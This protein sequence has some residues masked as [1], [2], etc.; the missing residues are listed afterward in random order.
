MTSP[1]R[2]LSHRRQNL[3][4]NT[5][6]RKSSGRV[7]RQRSMNHVGESF[8]DV[9][10]PTGDAVFTAGTILM[11][12]GS[13]GSGGLVRLEDGRLDVAAALDPRAGPSP[14][15]S[16]RRGPLAPARNQRA[17]DARTERPLLTRHAGVA[18]PGATVSRPR[19]VRFG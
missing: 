13:D 8:G 18:V 19:L 12:C 10:A 15:R 11:A 7:A 14:R 1:S 3:C 6:V 4:K 17:G 16:A 2:L 5:D 9:G